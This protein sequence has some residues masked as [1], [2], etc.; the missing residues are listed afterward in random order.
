MH[1]DIYWIVLDVETTQDSLPAGLTFAEI[2]A[3]VIGEASLSNECRKVATAAELGIDKT[4][5]WRKI[6]RLGI[7][8]E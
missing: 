4:T 8:H 2:E 7:D 6:K 3:R 5:L 1:V